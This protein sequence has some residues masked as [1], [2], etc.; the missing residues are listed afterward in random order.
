MTTLSGI[1]NAPWKTN[2][3]RQNLLRGPFNDALLEAAAE[4]VVAEL[5][6]L[7]EELEVG[8]Y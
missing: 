3:D 1:V 7:S 4:L 5:W 8:K 6:K 2:E